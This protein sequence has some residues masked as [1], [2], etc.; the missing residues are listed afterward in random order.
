MSKPIYD[1]I[2][3]NIPGVREP[4][5]PDVNWDMGNLVKVRS[6]LDNKEVCWRQ[7]STISTAHD[8]AVTTDDNDIILNEPS[9]TLPEKVISEL[10]KQIET[11]VLEKRQGAQTRAQKLKD[12]RTFQKLKVMKELMSQKQVGKLSSFYLFTIIAF[13]LITIFTLLLYYHSYVHYFF[14]FLLPAYLL[15]F[16]IFVALP[17]EVNPMSNSQI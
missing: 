10:S 13:I 9:D 5:N 6:K 11:D 1:L 7:E 8:K 2:L 15:L 17:I 12:G 4:N 3:G 16:F 14:T